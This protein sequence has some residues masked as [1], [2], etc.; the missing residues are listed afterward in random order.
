MRAAASAASVPAWPPPMTMTSN[1]SVKRMT[2]NTVQS[3][4]NGATTLSGMTGNR[5]F[6]PYPMAYES[7]EEGVIPTGYESERAAEVDHDAKH[8]DPEERP[9][10]VAPFEGWAPIPFGIG[11]ALMPLLQ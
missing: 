2:R 11:D 4:K 3:R 8:G 6:Q 7:G 10:T 1:S 9:T 5:Q